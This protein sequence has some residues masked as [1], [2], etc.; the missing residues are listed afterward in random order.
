MKF[1]QKCRTKKLGMTNTILGSFC[2]FWN[3]EGTNVRPQIRP[4]KIPDLETVSLFWQVNII[5]NIH[6]LFE[7]NCYCPASQE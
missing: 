4:R 3:L 1:S 5:I 2:S 6:L 7:D